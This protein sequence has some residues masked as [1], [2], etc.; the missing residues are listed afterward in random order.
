MLVDTSLGF[1]VG[2]LQAYRLIGLRRHRVAYAKLQTD[3]IQTH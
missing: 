3:R 1:L 2:L